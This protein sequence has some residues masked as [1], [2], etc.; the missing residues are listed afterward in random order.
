VPL[1]FLGL[2]DHWIRLPARAR[3]LI[4][5]AVVLHTWVLTAFR[6]PVPLSWRLFLSEG[7]QVSW[8]RVVRMT[9]NPDTWWLNTWMVPAAL[10]ATTIV[11][12]VCIW[13]YGDRLAV[14]AADART[15][16]I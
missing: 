8:L 16:E 1:L 11:V 13:Q 2:T 6:E 14:A 12:A 5:A 15:A 9:S 4:A 3:A 7:P 10:L